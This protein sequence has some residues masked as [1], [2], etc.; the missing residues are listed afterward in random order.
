MFISENKNTRLQTFV[1]KINEAGLSNY[2]LCLMKLRRKPVSAVGRSGVVSAVFAENSSTSSVLESIKPQEPEIVVCETQ[3]ETQETFDFQNV[4]IMEQQDSTPDQQD[5]STIDIINE[6]IALNQP[7]SDKG[8]VLKIYYVTQ[9]GIKPP[10]FIIFVNNKELFHFSY[11][12][13]LENHFRKSF[14]FEGTPIRI[15]SRERNEK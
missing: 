3:Q 11:E 4:E 5:E 9:S 6:A 14:G 13:Y 10:T 8:K 12:R 7:P 2:F 1:D 15:I